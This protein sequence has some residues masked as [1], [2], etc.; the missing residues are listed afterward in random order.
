M[1]PQLFNQDPE[2]EAAEAWDQEVSPGLAQL[3]AAIIAAPR[4]GN[5][6]GDIVANEA[7]QIFDANIVIDRV[8]SL[9]GSMASDPRYAYGKSITGTIEGTDQAVQIITPESQNNDVNNLRRGDVWSAQISIIDWD[10]LY[11]RIN[12]RQVDENA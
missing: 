11:N 4:H 10:S 2:D 8:A 6:R 3:V 12:A 7:G 9:M 5:E 1:A